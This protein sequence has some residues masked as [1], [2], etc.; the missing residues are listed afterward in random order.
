MPILL[1]YLHA[2]GAFQGLLLSCLLAVGTRISNS[3]RIL[4]GWCLLLALYFLGPFITMDGEI[5]LFS[6]LIGWS[7]FL[8]ASFG[9]FLYLYCR[10]A[11]IDKPLQSLDLWHFGPLL[12]CYLLNLDILLAPGE[13]KLDIILNNLPDSFSFWLS[14][15]ILFLQAFVYLGASLMLIRKYQKQANTTLSSFNPEIFRWLWTLLTLYFVIWTLKAVGSQHLPVISTL[16]DILILVLIYSIAMAQWRNPLLF[17]I[18]QFSSAT[19]NEV[20]LEEPANDSAQPKTSGALDTGLRASLLL[21]VRQHM[22]EQQ[23][24]LDNQL[25]LSSLA[26]AIGVSTHHLSEVLNQQEG[27]NFYQFVNKFRIEHICKQMKQDQ[28]GKIL[29]L[30]MN[31]GFSSKSTFNVV[32]KQFTGQTP[33]QYRKQ[34]NS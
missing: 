26:E 7:L 30:A 15:W 14:Q 5:N 3:S 32:F 25:T 34:L 11:I 33:T 8:P 31:A 29:D 10:H 4:G 1:Q 22:Q 17:R 23:A 19:V 9:A 13:V 2:I 18:E 21:L 16:A 27:S 6:S 20:Q 24:Y 12:L 28:S